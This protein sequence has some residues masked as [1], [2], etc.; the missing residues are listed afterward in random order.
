M[1]QRKHRKWSM[2]ATQL[3]SAGAGFAVVADEVRNL[4]L[5][6][7]DAAKT[8]GN[9][10]ESTIKAVQ[11]GNE[12]THLTQEAFRENAAISVKVEQLV[13]KIA[14][15]SQEQSQGIGQVNIAVTDMDKV[16]Q[17]TAASAEESAAAARHGPGAMKVTRPDQVIPL[18]DADFKD[19]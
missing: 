12:L 1:R 7:A 17:A 2:R 8:T 14:A 16:T 19:F 3:M 6:A 10:I 13:D 9:L 18:E 15:A 4:A 11:H 5:R